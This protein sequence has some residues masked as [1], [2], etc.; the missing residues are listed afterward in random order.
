MS[1]G[2]ETNR[3]ENSWREGLCERVKQWEKYRERDGLK[4][5]K[6]WVFVE[7]ERKEGKKQRQRKAESRDIVRE[8]EIGK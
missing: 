8:S 6:S 1:S 5:R 2:K 3:V 4:V 7:K